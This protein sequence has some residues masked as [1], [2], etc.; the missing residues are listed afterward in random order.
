MEIKTQKDGK[1]RKKKGTQREREREKTMSFVIN[2]FDFTRTGSD[3]WG[4]SDK[5]FRKMATL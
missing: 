2:F 5:P 4:Q 3:F 1:R